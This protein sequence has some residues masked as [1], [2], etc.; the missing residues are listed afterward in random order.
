MMTMMNLEQKKDK[1]NQSHKA[2]EKFNNKFNQEHLS[3][4]KVVES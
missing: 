3:P 2:Q 1:E 4:A